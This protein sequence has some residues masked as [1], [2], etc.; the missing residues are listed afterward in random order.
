MGR[1]TVP[2]AVGGQGRGESIGV[3]TR[4][5][6]VDRHRRPESAEEVEDSRRYTSRNGSRRNRINGAVN[7]IVKGGHRIEVGVA[8][9]L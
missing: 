2:A 7:V 3:R 1:A 9:V 4:I 5:L 8:D 6:C